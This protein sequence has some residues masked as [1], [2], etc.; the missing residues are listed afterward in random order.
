MTTQWPC[1]NSVYRFRLSSAEICKVLSIYGLTHGLLSIAFIEF[2]CLGLTYCQTEQSCAMLLRFLVIFVFVCIANSLVGLPCAAFELRMSTYIK[3][4]LLIMAQ[5]SSD[6]QVDLQSAFQWQSAVL[7]CIY[8][9]EFYKTTV[10]ILYVVHLA[11][12][13]SVA[14]DY[15]RVLGH[16]WNIYLDFS[17]SYL[18]YATYNLNLRTLVNISQMTK[19]IR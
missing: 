3:E 10:I 16:V 8:G 1:W 14:R 15:I 9:P 6:I 19:A 4:F 5:L 18:V 2:R 17:P 13:S 12:G 11:T 7:Q